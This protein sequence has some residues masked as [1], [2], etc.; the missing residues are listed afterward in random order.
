[1]PE[2][3]AATVFGIMSCGEYCEMSTLTLAFSSNFF[4]AANSASSSAL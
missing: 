3:S 1:M 4:T 2:S